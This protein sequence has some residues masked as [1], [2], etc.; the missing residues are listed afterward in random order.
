MIK[1]EN[2]E[3]LAYHG[4]Y[5]QEQIAGNRFLV[6][7]T[8]DCNLSTAS[9]SD[10]IADAVSYLEVYETVRKEMAIPSHLLENVARRIIDAVRNRF[11]KISWVK[12]EISKCNPPLGGAVE[13]VS[14][15]MEG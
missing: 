9:Q 13:K 10:D 14:V 6:S 15:I 12:V 3:F 4:C 2:M 7:L 1:L 11:P 5:E 8:Y